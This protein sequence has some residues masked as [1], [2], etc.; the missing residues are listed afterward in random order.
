MVELQCL[1]SCIDCLN[2]STV[3]LGWI[4]TAKIVLEILCFFFN[5]KVQCQFAIDYFA[6]FCQLKMNFTVL[7]WD[8]QQLYLVYVSSIIFFCLLKTVAIL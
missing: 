7:F 1:C 2:T 4:I 6:Q 3:D 8:L 5:H